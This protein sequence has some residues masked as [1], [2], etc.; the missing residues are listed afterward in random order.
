MISDAMA[1]E[2]AQQNLRMIEIL[3]PP[4][5]EKAR[6]IHP[7]TDPK[8]TCFGMSVQ[9]DFG[10]FSVISVHNPE[11]F[12]VTRK[13]DIEK[14]MQKDKKYHVWSFWDKKYLGI[15]NS[16][17]DVDLEVHGCKLLRLT[18]V[19]YGEDSPILIGSDLHISIGASEINCIK[20]NCKKVEVSLNPY[21]GARDGSLYFFTNKEP[22]N[23]TAIGIE[24]VSH[25]WNDCILTVTMKNRFLTVPQTVNIIF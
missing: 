5:L 2:T 9:R 25:T 7:A 15:K 13:A 4:A 1:D 18:P 24:T 3:T 10:N 8:L 23:V 16:D 21:A 11:G 6:P 17:F 19:V 14:F 22:S 12:E 20:N